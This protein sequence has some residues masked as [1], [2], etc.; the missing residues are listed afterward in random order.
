ML[1]VEESGICMMTLVPVSILETFDGAG[2][3]TWQYGEVD[4]H[5]ILHWGKEEIDPDDAMYDAETC[6]VVREQIVVPHQ[7]VV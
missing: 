4:G 5:T 7:R 6:G 1:S 2:Y 3:H